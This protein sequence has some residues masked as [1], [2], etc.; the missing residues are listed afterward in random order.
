MNPNAS[1]NDFPSNRR[2]SV[3]SPATNAGP[4][5]F[6]S[7]YRLK[8]QESTNYTASTNMERSDSFQNDASRGRL[9]SRVTQSHNQQQGKHR[10]GSKS[11]SRKDLTHSEYAN[12]HRLF[13]TFDTECSGFL[14]FSELQ[15]MLKSLGIVIADEAM[16]DI[17]SE[18]D[19]DD[20][21]TLDFDEFISFMLRSTELRV[22]RD[23][24]QREE[25]QH[26][27]QSSSTRVNPHTVWRWFWDL[28]VLVVT[29]YYVVRVPFEW[30]ILMPLDPASWVVESLITVV[31]LAD[32]GVYSNTSYVDE[33][34]R[35]VDD[36]Q[37]VIKKYAQTTLLADA[38]G[39]LPI[40]L[41]AAAFQTSS[42]STAWRI[43][44]V[45]RLFRV[46]RVIATL[47]P[48]SNT[49]G[50]LN[51]NMVYLN[52]H[53]SPICKGM[54]FFVAVV[55][56][57]TVG[58]I[59]VVGDAAYPYHTGLY[60]VLYTLTTVGF[61]DLIVTGQAQQLY[62]CMLFLCGALTNGIVISQMSSFLQ[63][64]N[65]E[66][67]R[68][69]KMR[70]T[71]AVLT[72]FDIPFHTQSE[73]LSFQSHVLEHNLGSSHEE[74]VSSL[75]V[76]I[77]DSLGL[78]MKIKYISM[79]PMFASADRDIKMA[80]AM[81]LEN[82][83]FH[84]QEFII[85]AGESGREMYFLGHGIADVIHPNG[86]YLATL[87]KGNF[88]GEI[89]LLVAEA[90]RTASIK[91]LTYCDVFRLEKQEFSHILGKFPAFKENVETEMEERVRT[92]HTTAKPPSPP[93]SEPKGDDKSTSS[94]RPKDDTLAPPQ[95][96][97]PTSGPRNTKKPGS[98][99][100]KN[101]RKCTIMS[102][103]SDRDDGPRGP[104]EMSDSPSLTPMETGLP[105]RES[106]DD[107]FSGSR[108]P[109]PQMLPFSETSAGARQ[110]SQK[111]NPAEGTGSSSDER[112]T[113][114]VRRRGSHGIAISEQ[115]R[116]SIVNTGK[117]ASMGRMPAPD[118]RRQS[119][120]G[121]QRRQPSA[122]ATRDGSAGRSPMAAGT[123][124]PVQSASFRRRQSQRDLEVRHSDDSDE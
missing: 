80:L 49:S 18:Y 79:V 6:T 31:L 57:L 72:H 71:L 102:P 22:R 63:K 75:P 107:G 76:T 112:P 105:L 13:N 37:K 113:A 66:A 109:V 50:L 43:V 87:R 60:L 85:I 91:A 74:L 120:A 21:G 35:G 119:S 100:P 58:W 20:N 7:D 45:L 104:L 48:D 46:V 108:S 4:V 93:D 38:L 16:A 36:L 15:T 101:L 40:D 81:G 64:A 30:T 114:T 19:E 33:T 82:I 65:I 90:K 118:L 124:A 67:D 17:R 94:D 41:I 3:T 117:I 54:F 1:I 122:G 83:I 73:I 5:A 24:V 69:D 12:F 47:F 78:F 29:M 55:H 61:G 103:K 111:Y 53:I 96:G 25:A 62:C 26:V 88:F 14:E 106:D 77:Q 2:K 8:P 70:E 34:G 56:I 123:P 9:D 115:Q 84:P 42:Y 10:S 110:S 98:L 59:L 86:F 121:L 39:A 89:A 23:E 68:V 92:F 116:K 28:A 99:S 44:R 11:S 97:S 95:R 27:S 51:P 52:Y 32:I